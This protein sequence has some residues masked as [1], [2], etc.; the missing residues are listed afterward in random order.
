MNGQ[1]KTWF[2]YPLA[3]AFF[4]WVSLASANPDLALQ[5]TGLDTAMEQ[6]VRNH[7]LSTWTLSPRLD[8]QR[9]RRAFLD[10][11]RN[12]ALQALRPWGYYK[13]D[14]EGRLITD[15]AKAGPVL[16]LDVRLGSPIRIERA[17]VAVTGPGAT[18][19]ALIEWWKQWPLEPN[20]TLNQLTWEE[21]KAQAR[22]LAESLGYLQARFTSQRIALDL[23]RDLATLELVLDTGQRAIMGK[24]HF[25]QDVVES[26]VLAP[27]S[28]FEP[29]DPYQAER[30]DELRIDLWK[31]GYFSEIEVREDPRKDTIPLVIDLNVRLVAR[32]KSTHQLTLG[33]G[34]DTRA[35]T[36]YSWT[37]HRLSSRGD[38]LSTAL[39]WRQT[40]SEMVGSMEYRLPRRTDTLQ[41]W[42][43]N[44]TLR[45]ENQEFLIRNIN[46]SDTLRVASGEV[47][48]AQLKPGRL[49]LID[50]PWSSDRIAETTFVAYLWERNSLEPIPSESIGARGGDFLDD[51]LGQTTQSISLGME[52]D[53]PV[54]RGRGFAT[55]GHHH[56]AWW[57]TANDA[58]GSDSNF[59]QVYLSSRWNRLLGD[60]WKLLV[61]GEVAY[62]DARVR[63]FNFG[64]E[65]EPL[66]V[67]ITELPYRYSFRTGGSQSV[68][69]YRYERLS[70]NGIGSNHLLVGSAELEYRL[71]EDW[72][73]AGFYDIG[74]AF[75]DWSETDLKRGWGFGVRWYSIV[76]SVR[77]DFGRA[78]D[79]EGRPW[80]FY[81]T[82]GTPLL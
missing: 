38:S 41:F 78:E 79:I 34:T 21:Q 53:W 24:I 76:G 16:Q 37:R 59:T 20:T 17:D 81:L 77:A 45:R 9:S 46:G 80:E 50:T 40:Y 2:F 22:E 67:S 7:M 43:V 3:L 39:G 29:G 63:S 60:R 14:I 23:E 47:F 64:S 66:E 6:N 19:P 4:A 57:F 36:Q 54:I 27:I 73:V 55:S 56:R 68:R 52:W 31:T 69:G 1:K 35:R 33:Y 71:L 72:S 25:D 12:L 11:A 8:T 51:L 61:R 44:G 49:R 42:T 65:E 26:G 5:I 15:D 13:P 32:H 28:R 30:I 58:W 82:I 74:N 18:E 70:S 10:Q 75:N 48:D 62:S